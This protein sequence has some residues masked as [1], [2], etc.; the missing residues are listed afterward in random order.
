METVGKTRLPQ[1]SKLILFLVFL[2]LSSGPFKK[3]IFKHFSL[4]TNPPR[5]IP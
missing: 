4:S 2:T 3:I 1:H 5:R